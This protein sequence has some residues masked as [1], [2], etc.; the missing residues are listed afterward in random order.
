MERLVER[1]D[2][3]EVF[4]QTLET[5]LRAS[6][7]T[8]RLAANEISTAGDRPTERTA[9]HGKSTESQSEIGRAH[10]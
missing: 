4:V 5:R 8:P 3:I 2:R 7:K 1:V 6:S 10:V 9:T